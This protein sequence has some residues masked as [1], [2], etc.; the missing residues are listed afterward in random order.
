MSGI[1]FLPDWTT[2]ARSRRQLCGSECLSNTISTDIRNLTE[3]VQE[4]ECMQDRGIYADAYAG[5]SCLDALKGW[6]GGESTFSDDCHGQSAPFAGVL[7]IGAE[8]VQ[9]PEHGGRRT[10]C[11]RH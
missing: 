4:A 10:V 11:C 7:N 2:D 9:S 5:V 1:G 6:P 3:A 8:L